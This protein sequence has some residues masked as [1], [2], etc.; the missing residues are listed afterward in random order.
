MDQEGHLVEV[1]KSLEVNGVH[2][3][4]KPVDGVS[5]CKHL[6]SS[7]TDAKA[8]RGCNSFVT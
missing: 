6:L 8:L 4:L 7:D 3:L 2:Y 1:H 5:V